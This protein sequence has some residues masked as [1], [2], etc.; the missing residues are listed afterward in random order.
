M[1]VTSFSPLPTKFSKGFF[2]KVVK[3]RDCVIKSKSLIKKKKTALSPFPTMFSTQSVTQFI[4]WTTFKMSSAN[5][6]KL[7][8]SQILSFSKEL[9]HFLLKLVFP[10]GLKNTLFVVCKIFHYKFS[11]C[12]NHNSRT[13]IV[14]L[15]YKSIIS[16]QKKSKMTLS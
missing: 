4:I 3:S 9:K 1:L 7:D 15:Q 8:W 14:M 6:F 16:V 12:T 11:R 2:F 5:A 10:T 13:I